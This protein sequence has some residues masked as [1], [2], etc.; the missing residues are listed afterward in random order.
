M[1]LGTEEQNAIRSAIAKGGAVYL[2]A[3]RPLSRLVMQEGV[4][5]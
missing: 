2:D 4:R 5:L 1:R 3:N